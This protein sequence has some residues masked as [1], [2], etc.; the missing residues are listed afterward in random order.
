MP[1]IA[2]QLSALAADKARPRAAPYTLAS[3]GGLFLLVLPSGGKQ[4]LVRYRLEDGR[5]SKVVIGAYPDLSVAGAHVK[6]DQVRQ[7][8]RAGDN[9]PSM[10]SEARARAQSQTEAELAA[11]VVAEDARR[12]SFIVVS[13]AWLAT[14]KAG[15]ADETYRK[16]R[17]VVRQYLQPAIGGLDVRTMR[18]RDVTEPLREIAASAPSLARKAVQYLNGVVD[19]CILEG[20]RDDDQVLRLRGVL[21]SHRGGHVPA[22]TREQDIGALMRAILGYEG[23]AVRSALL[24]AAWTA[25]RPGVIASARW[26][27]ID[28][29]RAE[30]HIPGMNADGTR[31]MK[32]GH[33]HLVSLPRQ[34]VVM[35]RDMQQYTGGAEYVFPAVGKMRNA[36]LHRDALSRALRLMGFAGVHSTH[37]FRAMLRTVAR[38]RLRVDF[39]VLEAQLAHAKR[40]AIQAAYDRTQFDD[41]RRATMQRWADYLERQAVVGVENVVSIA[42]KA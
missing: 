9:I 12:H 17:Y 33:D 35:L 7:A 4:W 23:V 1:K 41:E 31:R 42:R 26:G 24:L 37:G 22:I 14:R 13:D 39:D 27:E 8:A 6:A 18:T 28:L 34:A 20:M 25:L 38:E 21:P 5:R 15:W 10:R 32:T 16:A 3:G 19:H 30:W 11:R 40:D 29:E 36:H 2:K